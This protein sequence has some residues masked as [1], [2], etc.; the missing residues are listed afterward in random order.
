MESAGKILTL[1]RGVPF[2]DAVFRVMEGTCS[3]SDAA[4]ILREAETRNNVRF[5]T[6]PGTVKARRL[7][8]ELY[9]AAEEHIQKFLTETHMVFGG[10]EYS[11][12]D[13]MYRDYTGSWSHRAWDAL[14]TRWA[15]HE[16]WL[17]K[18]DWTY[19][20]FYGGLNDRVVK[21]YLAWSE[22]MMQVVHTKCLMSQTQVPGKPLYRTAP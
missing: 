18:G 9:V 8:D 16:K 1:E 14:V 2:V 22:A 7:P 13:V 10:Y 6:V 20:D 5:L 19:L 11:E 17:G 21:D 3:E 4:A 15:N 12:M